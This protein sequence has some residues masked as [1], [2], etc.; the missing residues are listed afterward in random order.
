MQKV[1]LVT[2]SSKGIGQAIAIRL[3]KDGYFVY[4][5]YLADKAGGEKTTGIINE[6]G[7]KSS[8]YD[9]DITSEES[10]KK[11]A[12][13]IEK[14]SGHVDVLV[15]SAERDVAKP[16]EESTLGEWKIAFDTKVHGAW[17]V[18]KFMLPLLK[19]SENANLIVIN[20]SA[21]E[22]R[23]P[24][25][26]SYATA[27]A[28]L[29]SMIKAWAVDFPK[30]GIRVNAV[31]PG[32]TRT[33]NWADLKNDDKLWEQFAKDNP[34]KRVPTVEEIADSVMYFVNDP[35]RYLNG[36]FLFVNGGNHW[37]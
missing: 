36:N 37:K 26:L 33:D 23:S 31:M 1:A 25:V 18:T 32:T 21:D 8:L 34:M 28:A 13:A 24:E 17:S 16:I 2:G 7:G 5:T 19:K 15:S 11:L 20:S 29:N 4:V 3:A 35:H 9:L 6:N 27:T 22:N 12:A 30:Y 10:V 14:E